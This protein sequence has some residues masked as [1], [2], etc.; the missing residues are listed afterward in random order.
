[1]LHSGK[2]ISINWGR[3]GYVADSLR[4]LDLNISHL[5]DRKYLEY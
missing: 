4:K 3:G 5:K 1:M 2:Q